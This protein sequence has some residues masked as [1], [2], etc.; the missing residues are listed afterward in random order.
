MTLGLVTRLRPKAHPPL[1]CWGPGAPVAAT[2]SA[3]EA[4]PELFDLVPTVQAIANTL[5][6][7]GGGG[8]A[9]APALMPLARSWCCFELAH[10]PEGRLRV[11][12]G[13]STWSVS[14]PV[15]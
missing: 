2:A 1:A 13:W 10:T 4:F 15:F 5:L 3:Q 12:V 8:G 11:R 6:I 9:C 7:L 14:L